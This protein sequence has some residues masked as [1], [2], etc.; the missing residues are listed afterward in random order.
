MKTDVLPRTSPNVHIREMFSLQGRVALVTGGAGRYGRQICAAL[1]EA[2]AMVIV[3]SRR[4]EKCE[5]FAA[6]LRREGF[7]AEGLALDLKEQKS[8][9]DAIS[10]IESRWE[11]LDVLFNNA[12]T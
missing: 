7:E 10:Q 1:A 12:V 5:E 4:M 8:V 3:A 9:E 6:C 2:G 11:K